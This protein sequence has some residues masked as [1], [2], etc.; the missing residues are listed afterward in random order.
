MKYCVL[1]CAL[2]AL[3][4]GAALLSARAVDDTVTQWCDTLSSAQQ[5]AQI[6]DWAQARVYMDDAYADWEAR[7]IMLHL[8]S[9]H[10]GLDQA[11]V[12][13]RRAAVFAHEGA[14]A[15][16]L[17]ETSALIAQLTNLRDAQAL[18]LRNIL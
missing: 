13:F 5:S 3:L 11:D 17:A 8:V 2:L 4:F 14:R 16:F 7:H 10:T 6:D 18:S 15:D 12:L 1:S 9:V